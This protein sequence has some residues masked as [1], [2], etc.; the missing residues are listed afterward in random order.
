MT[1][2]YNV[3]EKLKSG[4]ALD[5]SDRAIHDAGCVG[6]IHELHQKIDAAVAAAYGWP[7]DLSDDD[8]LSR[9]VALNKERAAEERAGLVRWLRPDYQIPRFGEARGAKK[10]RQIEA[11][12]EAPEPKA[13]ALPKDDA[14]LVAALRRA[15]RLIGKPAE[16]REIAARFRDGGRGTKRVER[17][18]HLLAA[19]GVAR[20]APEAG[21]FVADRTA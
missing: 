5:A 21:W 8:I 2:L 7:A 4:A 9:L 1:K 12:L 19:A 10:E 6:V 16:A 3:R 18:L 14:E 17:G 15:L 20:R 13:P 11:A